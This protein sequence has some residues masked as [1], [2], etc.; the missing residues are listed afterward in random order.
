MLKEIE[1]L[2]KQC[3]VFRINN[4]K[5]FGGCDFVITTRYLEEMALDLLELRDLRVYI[6]VGIDYFTRIARSCVIDNK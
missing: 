4:R 1:G 6:L 2:L 5:N 3:E